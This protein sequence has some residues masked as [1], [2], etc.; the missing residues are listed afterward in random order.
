MEKRNIQQLSATV[1][2]I[3][4]IAPKVIHLTLTL[5]E[6]FS[7]KPGQF[8]SFVFDAKEKRIRRPYSIVSTPKKKELEF[9]IKILEKG[10]L[11]PS[12]VQMKAGNTINII[13]PMG[14]FIIDE[15]SFGK[16]L[17]FVSHGV[18]IAPLKSM[19]EDILFK[20]FKY[21]IILLAGYK[22]KESI[23]YDEDFILLQK[24]YTNFTYKIIFSGG[25]RR[26]VQSLVGEHID[27]KAH[28]YLCG[29][30]EM[31][32][33]TRNLLHKKGVPMKSIFSEKFD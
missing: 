6:V 17:Y 4:E 24:K 19:I 16:D 5:D 28:Y 11:T 9:C 15:S 26:R 3:E 10:V 25:D 1:S 13:G 27:T 7:F 31:I 33:Q 21:N 20:G 30:K 29:L 8:V 14:D 12:L 2:S 32:S 22:D 18:G 23:L